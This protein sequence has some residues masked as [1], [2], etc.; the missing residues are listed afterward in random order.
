MTRLRAVEGSVSREGTHRWQADPPHGPKGGVSVSYK[1][2]ET[3]AQ[4]RFG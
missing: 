3:V 4:L 2:R 1:Q